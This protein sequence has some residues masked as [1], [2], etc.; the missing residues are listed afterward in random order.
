MPGRLREVH[1]SDPVLKL[2]LR[3]RFLSKVEAR[4]CFDLFCGTGTYY[5]ELYRQ[6]FA[7]VVCVDRSRESLSQVEALGGAA[8]VRGDN[9][10]LAAALCRQYGYPDFT[11][12]DAFGNPDAPLVAMLPFLG[13]IRRTA[14]VATDGTMAARQ[15]FCGVPRCWGYGDCKWSTS[16]LAVADYP[17]LIHDNLR[18]WLLP[19]GYV[20][21]AFEW[22]RRPPP[23]A[24][25]YYGALIERVAED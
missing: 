17:V 18:R 5:R 16:S 13:G 21:S 8:V 2:E 23:S 15:S 20:V 7:Q 25:I 9:A 22:H 24:V 19:L 1:N 4:L 10:R 6:H 11:D 3:R 12:L 14:V